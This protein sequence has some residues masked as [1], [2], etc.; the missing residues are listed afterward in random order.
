MFVCDSSY[1]QT[2]LQMTLILFDTHDKYYSLHLIKLCDIYSFKY[3]PILHGKNQNTEQLFTTRC[4]SKSTPVW[5]N[6]FV[7]II[8]HVKM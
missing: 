2:V 8:L 4:S 1:D 6:L 5:D 7:S 3:W